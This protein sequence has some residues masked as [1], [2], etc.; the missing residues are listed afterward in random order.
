MNTAEFLTERLENLGVGHVVGIPGDYILGFYAKLL[1]SKKL[2]YVGCT[3]ESHAGFVADGYARVHGV[4]CVAVTYNV[5]ALKIAN[6]VACAYAEKSPV[7]VISGAPQTTAKDSPYPL[8]HMVRSYDCQREM[9]KQITCAQAILDN[10]ST[11][12]YEIDRVL[13]ALDHNKQPVYIELCRDIANRP[14]T[15]NVYQ[16]GTPVKPKSDPENLADALEEVIGMLRSAKNPVVLAGVEIARYRLGK[17]LL[18]FIEANN[19]PVASTLL[20]KSVVQELHS[21]FLGVYAG[22]VTSNEYVRKA[23]DES[24]CLLVLG[25]VMT[26]S[27]VGYRPSKLFEKTQMI[28]CT[29]SEGLR[30]RKHNYPDVQFVDFCEALFVRKGLVATP[31][32]LPPKEIPQ[33]T[34]T[35]ASGKLTSKRFFEAVNAAVN[36]HRMSVIADTGE[37]LFGSA[38]I[39]CVQEADSYLGPAY[40]LS[41]GFAIPAALGAKLARPKKKV[42]V[43]VGDGAFQMS[44]SEIS[45]FVQLGLDVVIVVLNNGGYTTERLLA[46]GSFNDIRD[47]NYH[48][49]T[50]MIGGGTGHLV[51][52][53]F[54]LEQAL[55]N[56]CTKGG[57]HVLN[58]KLDPLDIS[59][60]LR[61]MTG[62]LQK[63][64]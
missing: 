55:A 58:V 57:V 3:D 5:G 14:I 44:V 25:E 40:Y 56:A 51:N 45:N 43:L 48:K 17:D 38:D 46:D 31:V 49:V 33:T 42:M 9:F 12:A 62:S 10:P 4:G 52:T 59:P 21:N 53:E 63:A 60:A 18:K 19:L 28:T 20:S 26:E 50:E 1:A 8:H 61:R 24:D 64:L 32:D 16:Q 7:I 41:M 39:V 2:K 34:F 13:E 29:S 15:Y 54:D 6:A 23:V 11:A 47:W 27:T 30:V 35:P 36:K 37:S 22:H